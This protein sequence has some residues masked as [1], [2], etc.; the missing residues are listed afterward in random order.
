M[1]PNDP[2]LR[3]SQQA[4]SGSQMDEL[5][6]KGGY[7]KEDGSMDYKTVNN[8]NKQIGAAYNMTSDDEDHKHGG[9]PRGNVN[10]G[11]GNGYHQDNNENMDHMDYP[12]NTGHMTNT[13]KSYSGSMSMSQMSMSQDEYDDSA[14]MED[15]RDNE[16]VEPSPQTNSPDSPYHH[17]QDNNFGHVTTLSSVSRA[18]T[19]DSSEM[20]PYG[21]QAHPKFKFRQKELFPGF[22]PLTDTNP[23]PQPMHGNPEDR[24]NDDI[25][26]R[27]VRKKNALTGLQKRL[28]ESS[29]PTLIEAKK[30][31]R[32]EIFK[33]KLIL[34]RAICDFS[35]D[36]KWLHEKKEKRF[37]F[38]NS[39]LFSLFCVVLFVV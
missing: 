26:D 8:A 13:S 32:E 10:N 16:F 7:L 17:Q 37:S 20:A 2:R 25:L 36:V 6:R 38:L 39:F 31:E 12:N 21:N 11:N 14:Y 34:C 22:L 4:P 1:D 23:K 19:R 18:M 30:E 15:Q 3:D 9:H 28:Y 5:L 27:F 35:N 33:Q 29:F 24:I